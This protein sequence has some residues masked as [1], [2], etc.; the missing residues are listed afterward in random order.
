MLEKKQAYKEPKN[1]KAP[2]IIKKINAAHHGHHG[3]AWKVAYA[4]FVT[5]MM[6]FF[7]L[8]WLLNSVPV[9][10][11]EGI[12][13]YFEPTVGVAGSKGIGFQGGKKDNQSGIIS[14]VKQQGVKY[15]VNSVGAVISNPEVGT[16]VSIEEAENANFTIMEGEL[17]KS[18]TADKELAAFQDSIAFDVT[19]EGLQI[20]L[21]DQEKYPL[22]KPGK[23]E[24]ETYSK[25]IMMKIATLIK[26]SPNFISISG[27]TDADTAY[28]S[29]IYTNWEL[30]TDRANAA[31][32]FLV[33]SG[34][35]SDRIARIVGR[36]DTDPIDPANPNAA[37]NRRVSITL[38]RNSIMPF[39]K[40]SAPKALLGSQTP[41][42]EV[43]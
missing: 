37:R 29:E 18:I 7:L 28:L 3:G 1:E 38:L 12:A 13:Q 16:E 9:E 15:G 19:P 33:S 2:I 41:S 6:A 31:R 24:L 30:S 25:N 32:K 42:T 21:I 39:S 22:F 40:I 34:I 43:K 10:K 11:L 8:L 35:D 14:D 36:A 5:A 20:K 23:A 4:D 26:Y 17:K 27:H